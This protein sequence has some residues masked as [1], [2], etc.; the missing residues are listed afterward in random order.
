MS[1]MWEQAISAT[2]NDFAVF[3]N[4]IEQEKPP[5]SKRTTALGKNA[6]F[7]LDSLLKHREGFTA[8]NYQQ[9]SYPIIDLM[10]NLALLGELYVK[11]ADAKGN[12]YLAR[13][14]RKLEFNAL[15]IYE[16]YAFL[17]QTFWTRYDLEE[18]RS[19][20]GVEQCVDQ[21]VN[22]LAQSHPG[23]E[24]LKGTFSQR[25]DH[26]PVYSYLS[27]LVRY[28][29]FFGFCRYIPLV[30]V[31]KK[32]SK[33]DDSIH[34][35]IP[36]EFGVQICSLLINHRIADWNIPSLMN[37]FLDRDHKKTVCKPLYTY[38][39]PL[40]P[41]DSLLKTVTARLTKDAGGSF[42][43]KVSLGR[44]VWRK[45]KVSY[46]H[47]LEDLHLV[48]Q[49]AF[50][51]DDDHL[52]SFFLDAKDYSKNCYHCPMSDGG[53]FVDEVTIG[54]LGLYVGQRMVYLFDY[55]ASWEFD[56]QLEK[57]LTDELPPKSP[58]IIAVRGEAPQQYGCN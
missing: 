41:E 10:V 9:Q 32:P 6:L 36:S 25:P 15:N 24:L 57:I 1:R 17:L 12:I 49:E 51:F 14:E 38:L 13:T 42:V 8:P 50:A 45:V 58:E 39:Q 5:L 53:P 34:A 22:V 52:Y 7:A 44:G 30:G 21:M 3:C 35:I 43:F 19:W 54:E 40:F 4:F 37:P 33:Y 48:I 47:T 31:Y 18:L 46:Q 29:T 27:V 16:Q 55:G 26:D 28:L 20:G 56:L 2:V 23:D 11:A